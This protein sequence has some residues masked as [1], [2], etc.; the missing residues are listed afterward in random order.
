M[1]NLLYK[2]K[3]NRY[4]RSKKY[5]FK[6]KEESDLDI[7]IVIEES[8][9]I[10]QKFA[11]QMRM[12]LEKEGY[13]VKISDRFDSA[14]TINHYFAP[15]SE[16]KADKRTTFMITHVMKTS[17]LDWISRLTEKGAVGI[18]MSRQT[19]QKL[20]SYGIRHNRI[21]YINPAQDGEIK[22]RKYR[23][24]FTHRQYTDNRKRDTMILDVCK[25][26]NP[27]MFCFEI[28]G[29]GWDNNVAKMREMGFEVIYYPAFDRQ[30][31][32]N[33]MQNLDYYCY[34][35]FDEGSMGFLDAVAAG[36][37]TI[38]SPQGYHLDTCCE[39]TYPVSTVQ[40]IIDAFQ[41]LES[42]KKKNIEFAKEATWA[43]YAKKHVEIWQYLSGQKRLSDILQN[44]GWY[45]DGIFSFMLD[46]LKEDV[47][48]QDYIKKARANQ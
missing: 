17:Y 9:W 8:G 3:Y 37:G 41:D 1:I 11:E 7:N 18:C 20:I 30:K 27:E 35:G 16:R 42:K 25:E 39:I 10:L 12:E 33:M 23:I 48:L 14:C 43:N 13:K 21:C 32:I 6:Y 19:M 38:V 24:G 15:N 4:F 2:L 22:P 36:I 29:A 31:Y 44:R 28:M 34:F 40:E 45:Q 5:L 26:I 47:Q 46:E